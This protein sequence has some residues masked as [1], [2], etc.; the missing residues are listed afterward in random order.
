MTTRLHT[1]QPV[2][3]QLSSSSRDAFGKG[4]DRAEKKGLC[5]RCGIKTH[6]VSFGRRHA[7]SNTH[8]HD[9]HCIKCDPD[10]VPLKICV[11]WEQNNPDLVESA[12]RTQLHKLR[13][14]HRQQQQ[15]STK[16]S[17]VASEQEDQSVEATMFSNDRCS[18]CGTQT[19]E[20]KIVKAGGKR[21]SFLGKKQKKE[22]QLVPLTIE[23]AVLAGRC[24]TCHPS[25]R[26]K[27][28]S[29]RKEQAIPIVSEEEGAMQNLYDISSR[30]A[31]QEDVVFTDHFDDDVP[32]ISRMTATSHGESEKISQHSNSKALLGAEDSPRRVVSST[33]KSLSSSPEGSGKPPRHPGKAAVVDVDD[34]DVDNHRTAS[35]ADLPMDIKVGGSELERS[36]E[37]PEDA[38]VF[39]LDS[40]GDHHGAILDDQEDVITCTTDGEEAHRVVPVNINL[41]ASQGELEEH[42]DPRSQSKWPAPWPLYRRTD[43]DESSDSDKDEPGIPFEAGGID[44]ISTVS[45][46][47]LQGI[48]DSRMSSSH[49]Q[50]HHYRQSAAESTT[51][52]SR[53]LPTEVSMADSSIQPDKPQPSKVIMPDTSDSSHAS[54]GMAQ[55]L[56]QESRH[57]K[58]SKYSKTSKAVSTSNSLIA[59]MM[60]S[61]NILA[62]MQEFVQNC[63]E[64]EFRE[65]AAE[66]GGILAVISCM[67]TNKPDRAIQRQGCFALQLLAKEHG[68]TIAKQGGINALLSAIKHHGQNDAH[69]Y[70][71]ACGALVFV[72][73]DDNY[74]AAVARKGGVAYILVGAQKHMNH[75]N[76]QHQSCASLLRLSSHTDIVDALA[77]AKHQGIKIVVESMRRHRGDVLLQQYCSGVL[78]N[79]AQTETTRAQI[80]KEGG[81]DALVAAIKVHRDS[82]NLQQ[83]ACWALDEISASENI[84]D[85]GAIGAALSAMHHYKWNAKV[86]QY[87]CG[88]LKNLSVTRM[89]IHQ[90]AKLR[91]IEAM[92]DAMQNHVDNAALQRCACGALKHLSL[93]NTNERA[94]AKLGGIKIVIDA[95]K[96]HKMDGTVQREACG[97]LR[98]M[99]INDDNKGMIAE[100]GGVVTLLVAMKLSKHDPSLQQKACGAL[101]NLSSNAELRRAIASY[102]G[103]IA[104][105]AIMK[106]LSSDAKVQQYA[107]GTLQNLAVSQELKKTIATNEGI[108][109]V[110]SAMKKHLG[111]EKVQSCGCGALK[112]LAGNPENK[113]E[114]TK[115]KGVPIIIA[116]MKAHPNVASLQQEACATL[117]ALSI[118][119]ENTL[120]IA[121]QGGIQTIIA[122]M[123]RH[124]KT[125]AV[126]SSACAALWSLSASSANM[127]IISKNSGIRM[128]VSRMK[129]HIAVS[130]V[131]HKACLAL[132]SMAASETT[133]AIIHKEKGIEV[134]IEGMKAHARNL[135]VQKYACKFLA[136][137][138]Q[139]AGLIDEVALGVKTVKAAMMFHADNGDLK[140]HAQKIL[141]ACPHDPSESHEDDF[142]E[143]M[144]RSTSVSC[145]C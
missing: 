19:H 40:G 21:P 133:R 138:V 92:L 111:E 96:E 114:I 48:D 29:A 123:E 34:Y 58:F 41:D 24:L 51:E 113:Q 109:A 115:H 52:I 82:E 56:A 136:A 28:P 73:M 91:G 77:S 116:A 46:L 16:K 15:Q 132:S 75:L 121:K 49:H 81:V 45:S 25:S 127:S 124:P 18:T 1:R 134:A 4:K 102:G 99:S 39:S 17:S 72:V 9:G 98:N 122:A 118:I 88:V 139:S 62:W 79:I 112:N 105:V 89:N 12:K 137:M 67:K 128:I 43:G 76:V 141:D 144:G 110:L 71:Y 74:K 140:R 7:L 20:F 70:E 8:V 10:M 6:K 53:G 38:E 94:I 30:A 83:Q 129:M 3:R 2:E 106:H 50:L 126:Q 61:G 120:S 69:L 35:Q 131:V 31:S 65:Q 142:S 27:R 143:L 44:A 119:R 107:C 59:E 85:K 32:R 64:E 54:F 57:S 97:A 37:S 36:I 135:H 100:H 33:A 90:I 60:Q 63:Q 95:M 78:K 125:S 42:D 93:S 145:D 13:G 55:S 14:P 87:G 26:G 80:F 86:Q 47:N 5:P 104:I 84:A 23:G 101:L 22:T 130:T 68:T 117:L 103:V 11:D 108:P 66:R